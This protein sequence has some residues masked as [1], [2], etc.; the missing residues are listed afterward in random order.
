VI[1]SD[2]TLCGPKRD[3]A[4]SGNL[5]EGNAVFEKGTNHLKAFEGM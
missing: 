2:P 5:R 1:A 3:A 4:I